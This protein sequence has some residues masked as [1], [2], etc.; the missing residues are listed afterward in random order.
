[1]CFVFL[2]SQAL[3]LGGCLHCCI[4]EINYFIHSSASTCN[5]P[6]S[7]AWEEH[8]TGVDFH[9][10]AFSGTLKHPLTRGYW[11][12]FTGE[13]RPW[14]ETFLPTMD[15]V[16]VAGAADMNRALKYHCDSLASNQCK[17]DERPYQ[18]R[19]TPTWAAPDQKKK[20]VRAF[21]CV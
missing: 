6:S 17:Q 21:F 15:S 9:S 8:K 3:T 12:A 7:F 2:V 13:F 18:N 14:K 20:D 19:Q 11:R 1:M 16:C 5:H 10:G 4:H